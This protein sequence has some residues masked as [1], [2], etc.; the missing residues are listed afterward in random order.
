MAL[1]RKF[2][3]WFGLLVGW[4]YVNVSGNNKRNSN[5]IF[6]MWLTSLAPPLWALGHPGKD[7]WALGRI[8]PTLIKSLFGAQAPV[9]VTDGFGIFS[10]IPGCD[11]CSHLQC[12][13][14]QS[15]R[16]TRPLNS[17][18]FHL[19][20]MVPLKLLST[21]DLFNSLHGWG[22]FLHL[23]LLGAPGDGVVS[24]LS[25]S[26]KVPTTEIKRCSCL[27][28]FSKEKSLSV[29]IS[30]IPLNWAAEKQSWLFIKLALGKCFSPLEVKKQKNHSSPV[31]YFGITLL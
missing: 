2:S 14:W 22:L 6:C 18:S 15:S 27:C 1:N 10:A 17:A 26:E 24:S 7:F 9:L 4:F 13:D 28:H 5:F 23:E 19:D 11:F 16:E 29:L 30:W 21:G 20:W 8:S 25:E 31:S 3:S 12:Q